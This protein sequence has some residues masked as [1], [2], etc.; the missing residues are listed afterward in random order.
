MLPHSFSFYLHIHF[1]KTHTSM[2]DKI[3]C[4]QQQSVYQKVQAL[5]ELCQF[6]ISLSDLGALYQ[7]VLD[8]HSN[9][10]ILNINIHRD[11][12]FGFLK[13]NLFQI[14]RAKK[15]CVTDFLSWFLQFINF[16]MIW[17]QWSLDILSLV[18]IKGI[19]Y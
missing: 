16:L 4:Y 18:V 17:L 7:S 5:N 9:K 6:V 2:R 3:F 12:Y 10:V 15:C 8:R 19:E 13:H 11:W 1:R 14:F